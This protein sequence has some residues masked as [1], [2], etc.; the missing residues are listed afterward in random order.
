[1]FGAYH[2]LSFFFKILS[3]KR[4]LILPVVWV[5]SRNDE[6]LIK[7]KE[8]EMASTIIFPLYCLT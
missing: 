1:M 7:K 2:C 8:E 4:T 5:K 6:L 3:N